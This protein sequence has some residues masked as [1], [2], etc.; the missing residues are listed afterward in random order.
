MSEQALRVMIEF[1][2]ISYVVGTLSFSKDITISDQK[3]NLLIEWYDTHPEMHKE[4]SK[5]STVLTQE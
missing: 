1:Q 5:V 4:N 3:N 2:G